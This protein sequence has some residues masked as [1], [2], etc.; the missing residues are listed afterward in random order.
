MIPRKENI[1]IK[2]IVNL[3]SESV[4]SIINCCKIGRI[5]DFNSSNWSVTVEI[6]QV[7]TVNNNSFIPTIL[8]EVP[9]LFY[10]VGGASITM[11]NVIGQNCLLLFCDR[12]IDNFLLTGQRYKPDNAR[13]HSFAD[14]V[15]LLTVNSFVDTPP[16]YDESALTVNNKDNFIKIYNDSIELYAEKIKLYN[17]QTTL[18]TLIKSLIE[19]IQKITVDTT[20]SNTQQAINNKAEF[21]TIATNFGE[22]LQ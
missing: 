21:D 18:L 12:N 13:K 11:P 16:M 10:G 22:L 20:T 3:T 4:Q 6:L 19:E 14:A 1:D 15:A 7:M 8:S 17:S 9:L 5:I 2:D